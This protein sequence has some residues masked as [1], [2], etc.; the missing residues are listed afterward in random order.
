MAIFC[1]TNKCHLILS[2][3]NSAWLVTTS[4]FV[5]ELFIVLILPTCIDPH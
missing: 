2:I 1:D 4:V 3:A 5:Y